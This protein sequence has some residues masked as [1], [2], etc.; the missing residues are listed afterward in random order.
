MARL[1]STKTHD[2]GCGWWLNENADGSLTVRNPDK[3][4]RIN[5]PVESVSTLKSICTRVEGC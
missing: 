5:L 3:G 2:L 4:Q 1:E